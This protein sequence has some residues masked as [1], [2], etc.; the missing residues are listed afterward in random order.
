MVGIGAKERPWRS[1]W[2]RNSLA[3]SLRI[4]GCAEVIFGQPSQPTLQKYMQEKT[5]SMFCGLLLIQIIF[6][7]ICPIADSFDQDPI[8]FITVCR[9]VHAC[10]FHLSTDGFRLDGK[11]FVTEI[12][13]VDKFISGQHQSKVDLWPLPVID[14]GLKMA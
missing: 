13:V 8:D 14:T 12:S 11:E 10:P 2:V 9:C 4:R 7:P 1:F 5:C 3:A 6:L